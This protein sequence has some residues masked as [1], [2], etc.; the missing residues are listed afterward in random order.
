MCE[1]L[2]GQSERG[3]WN[4]VRSQY[5]MKTILCINMLCQH[6]FYFQLLGGLFLLIFIGVVVNKTVCALYFCLISAIWCSCNFG[7][8]INFFFFCYLYS[9]NWPDNR[10]NETF[11]SPLNHQYLNW[12]AQQYA[13]QSHLHCSIKAKTKQI[14]KIG[15]LAQSKT[16]QINKQ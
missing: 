12:N 6:L 10:M 14:N 8:F 3:H 5:C 9:F 4:C 16:P 11:F 15:I 7:T 13:N 1:I 2:T